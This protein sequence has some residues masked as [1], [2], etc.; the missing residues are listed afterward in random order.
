M[1]NNEYFTFLGQQYEGNWIDAYKLYEQA[2]TYPT[3]ASYLKEHG[4]EIN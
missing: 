4:K 2:K 1:E 3:F